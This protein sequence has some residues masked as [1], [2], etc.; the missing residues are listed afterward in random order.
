V[1][2]TVASAWKGTVLDDRALKGENIGAD[3]E[4]RSRWRLH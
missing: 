2:G 4:L 3:D 1:P